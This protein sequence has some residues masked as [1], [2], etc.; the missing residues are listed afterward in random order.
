MDDDAAVDGDRWIDRKYYVNIS[1]GL[2]LVH[3]VVNKTNT[4]TNRQK[5]DR[6][7]KKFTQAQ[8]A[9]SLRIQSHFFIRRIY[10]EFCAHHSDTYAASALNSQSS[11]HYCVNK[12]DVPNYR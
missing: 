8:T 3:F 5:R 12:T 11:P 1:I 9:Y 10:Y 4:H 7:K 6:I 2:L